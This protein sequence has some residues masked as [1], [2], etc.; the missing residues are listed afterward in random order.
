MGLFPKSL[1]QAIRP[2]RK[3]TAVGMDYDTLC[4]TIAEESLRVRKAERL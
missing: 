3:A 2:V 4:E 1:R